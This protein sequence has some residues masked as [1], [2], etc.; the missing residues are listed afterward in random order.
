[1][2]FVIAAYAIVG[3]AVAGYVYH[4]RRR[5]KALLRSRTGD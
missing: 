1:M 4:L 5:R 3:A 2:G